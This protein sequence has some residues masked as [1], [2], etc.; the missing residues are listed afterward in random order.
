MAPHSSTLA[1]KIPWTEEPGRLQSMESLRVRHNWVTSLSLFTFMHWRRK[2][3]PTP[4]FL[5]GESQGRGSLMG[6]RHGVAQSQ[7]RLKRLSSSSRTQIYLTSEL[8]S[9]LL[10]Q[11]V[12]L[13]SFAPRF[14][15]DVPMG[16]SPQ[17]GFP[18][19]SG[20]LHRAGLGSHLVNSTSTA[21]WNDSHRHS[22]PYRPNQDLYLLPIVIREVNSRL[23]RVF[24][25]GTV[26]LETACFQLYPQAF[27]IV[28][29]LF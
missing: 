13:N 1:W 21:L 9:F 19:I 12:D 20:V 8:V 7:T 24:L 3:Q 16:L 28:G 4:V 2:W 6:C 18:L 17:V 29:P 10:Y 15:V 27:H 14:L 25:L 5:P 26:F 11:G 23:F 22:G